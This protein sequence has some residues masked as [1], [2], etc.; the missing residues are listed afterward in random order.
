MKVLAVV[1]CL[2]AAASA[3][4]AYTF[5]DG[6]LDIL[7]AEPV[8]NFDCVGRAYGYYADV[9][10]DCRVFHVC[11]P[12]TDDAGE[13]AET[14]H[15]SFFCGNQTI[16]SQESLTCAHSDLAFPCDEAESLYESSNADF[17]VIPE[18]N[19]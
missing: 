7:G 12:I 2:A 1:L 17:G 9:S 16:F 11:L 4:M 18:E 19:Q 3:R 5:S 10:T 15:F 13:L 14:A 6:Y 8:Q